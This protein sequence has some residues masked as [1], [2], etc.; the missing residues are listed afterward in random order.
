MWPSLV[1]WAFDR[2]IRVVRLVVFNHSYFGFKSGSGTMDATAELLSEDVVRL[3]LCRPP[4]FHWSPGQSAYL[5][6]PS[7]ST[8]PFEA[9]PFAIASVY[10]SLF[11]TTTPEYSPESGVNKDIQISA[12]SAPLWKEL[13]FLVKV[14]KGFTK[15]LKAVAV[16]GGKIKV[17][18]DG[19][20]GPSPDLSSY[21]TCILVAGEPHGAPHYYY[22]LMQARRVRS[23]AHP[24]SLPKRHRVCPP[25][26]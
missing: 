1:F 17:F 25:I 6:M 13:V 23:F 22:V 2:L 5:T 21:D 9:H 19:P 24:P 18:V 10:S 20:Y 26:R 16:R 15:K 4:H 8:V 11:Q 3:R 14:H 7:V 12:S